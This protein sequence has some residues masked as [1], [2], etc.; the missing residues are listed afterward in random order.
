MIGDP[1]AAGAMQPPELPYTDIKYVGAADFYFAINATFVHI[2]QRFGEEG[3]HSY[4]QGL[5]QRYQE[6]VWR[7]WASGGLPSV[8]DYWEEFF[9][10]E[11]AA[12]AEV[13]RSENAVTLN[14]VTCPAITHLR[15]HGREI[16]PQ[17]C[18]HCSVMGDAAAESAGLQV[19]VVGGN[20]TCVQTFRPRTP[21]FVQDLSAITSCEGAL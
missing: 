18:Q 9:R 1:A 2:L 6:P 17:F 16:L 7:R 10:H 5:G 20:G 3:L 12:V 13:T 19:S 8:A 15:K 21:N 14:V 11:P 4:W